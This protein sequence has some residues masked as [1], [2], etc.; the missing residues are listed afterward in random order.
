M[1]H[2]MTTSRSRNLAIMYLKEADDKNRSSEDKVAGTRAHECWVQFSCGEIA[3]P[4]FPEDR[5][6]CA[7]K[8]TSGNGPRAMI[9]MYVRFYSYRV[10]Y[11]P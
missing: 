3:V 5:P 9:G 10:P 6:R 2:F 1:P 8:F 4:I 7:F 11:S